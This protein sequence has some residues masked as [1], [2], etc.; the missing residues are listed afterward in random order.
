MYMLVLNTKKHK[1]KEQNRL[2]VK[3][4]NKNSIRKKNNVYNKL[5][6]PKG[7]ERMEK[8]HKTYKAYKNHVI[9]LSRR[10]KDSYSKNL[11]E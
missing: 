7:S 8:L 6:R 5:C 3:N 2:L 4:G 10:S 11:F 9:N 1:N